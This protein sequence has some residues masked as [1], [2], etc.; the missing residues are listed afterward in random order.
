ME[1]IIE[2]HV[3]IRF[4]W[5]VS[6]TAIKIF[7]MIEKVYCES[8]VYHATVFRWYNIFSEGQESIHDEQRSGKPTKTRKNIACVADILKGDRPAF[9][10]H[11][12]YSPSKTYN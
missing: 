4:S 11:L 6:F 2:Q 1:K 3:V 5:K 12:C 10:M 9:C 8:I 7:E